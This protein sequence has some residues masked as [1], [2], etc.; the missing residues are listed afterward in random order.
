[1]EN[2]HLPIQPFPVLNMLTT[3]TLLD[4][5]VY[6][7]MKH[8]KDESFRVF[9]IKD[10]ERHLTPAVL[11]R[12]LPLFAGRHICTRCRLHLDTII[13]VKRGILSPHLFEHSKYTT[14]KDEECD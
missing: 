5:K 9:G 12:D 10:G 14:S 6:D 1:M 11:P 13:G 8:S 3:L 7:S 2:T 4:L